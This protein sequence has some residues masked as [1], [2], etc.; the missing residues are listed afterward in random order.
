MKP[1]AVEEDE[2]EELDET[3]LNYMGIVGLLGGIAAALI[4][5]MSWE[6]SWGRAF[7]APAP[8]E[9]QK[10][11]WLSTPEF[12]QEAATKLAPDY[13]PFHS[14]PSM[15]EKG[16]YRLNAEEIKT[17]RATIPGPAEA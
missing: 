4:A 2:E 7:I 9:S 13:N 5:F 12:G 6:N 1:V 15:E 14:P 16:E 11:E 10:Q 17:Q 8:D 3:P